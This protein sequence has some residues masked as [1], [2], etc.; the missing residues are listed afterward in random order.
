M[1]R[2]QFITLVGG[3]ALAW[4]LSGLLSYGNDSADNFRC[5]ATYVDHVL[6]GE[7][8]AELPVQLPVKFDLVINLKTAKALGITIPS[9]LLATANEV[10]E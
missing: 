7:N 8:P 6:K 4:P 3:A 2:G 9:S 5:A 10:I 1:K